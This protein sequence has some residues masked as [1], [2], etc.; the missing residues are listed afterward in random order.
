VAL[1]YERSG[2]L[3]LKVRLVES[4]PSD[5]MPRF[6]ATITTTLDLSAR[7][8]IQMRAS[9][10]VEIVAIVREFVDTFRGGSA[11]DEPLTTP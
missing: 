11:G 10:V 5:S 2:L 1:Q 6:V 4:A 7:D 9:S 3:I 8:E